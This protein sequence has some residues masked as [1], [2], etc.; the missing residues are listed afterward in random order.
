M[1]SSGS[2]QIEAR[3]GENWRTNVQGRDVPDY[4]KVQGECL[5]VI[6]AGENFHLTR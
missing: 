6:P 1:A 4:A 3:G 2:A 5:C